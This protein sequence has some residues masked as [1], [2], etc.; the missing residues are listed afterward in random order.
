MLLKGAVGIGA[1]IGA[2]LLL[3]QY[4]HPNRP[5]T[6]PD[7][8]YGLHPTEKCDAYGEPIMED[9][10]GVKWN[11]STLS[12]YDAKTQPVHPCSEEELAPYLPP[13][14]A[15]GGQGAPR[16][17]R[18]A[19]AQKTA[20]LKKLNE[21]VKKDV[22]AGAKR[23]QAQYRREKRSVDEPSHQH[24]NSNISLEKRQKAALAALVPSMGTGSML[25]IGAT[26]LVT[27]MHLKN[28]HEAKKKAAYDAWN[29]QYH[30]AGQ[31]ASSV[32]NAI[33]TGV[34]GQLFNPITGNLV[35]V[36][37]NTNMY[38]DSGTG[39]QVS[40][41]T[42]MPFKYGDGDDDSSSS[43]GGAAGGAGGANVVLPLLNSSLFES[44]CL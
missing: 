37:P 34:N 16:Q 4:A 6:T 27:T 19:A 23:L 8:E 18:D 21:V 10:R 40:P 42:G 22:H 17:K 41:K 44:S 12:R 30:S 2:V 38:Y 31:A 26:A 43:G 28:I 7:N 15:Q 33:S 9:F 24:Y 5:N 11:K 20:D 25:A 39:E 3:D 29:S 36:D 1:L 13:P 14:D 32:G 35:L